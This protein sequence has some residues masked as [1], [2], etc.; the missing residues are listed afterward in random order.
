MDSQ[1]SS[2]LPAT[3]KAQLQKEDAK[4]TKVY[5]EMPKI[6][7]LQFRNSKHSLGLSQHEFAFGLT[8]T[9]RL[10]PILPKHISKRK[11]SE[12]SPLKNN[13]NSSKSKDLP[14]F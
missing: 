4:N 13:V 12:V 9:N 7:A 8:A 2:E 5:S 6:N 3:L 14:T 10:K 1:K 11:T